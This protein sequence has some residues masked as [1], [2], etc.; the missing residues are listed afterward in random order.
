M[1]GESAR[2]AFVERIRAALGRA[3]TVS[4]PEPP[5]PPAVDEALVR[6]VKPETDLAGT[7]A[8]RAAGA[9]MK[10]HRCAAA[11]CAA[12]V[13]GILR[14][15]RAARVWVERVEAGA[16]ELAGRVRAAGIGVVGDECGEGMEALFDLDAGVTGVASAIA[17]TGSVVLASGPGRRRGAFMVPP[18]H[19][20]VVH[21]GQIVADLLDL[22]GRIGPPP[23][24]PTALTIVSGPSKTADIEGILITGVHGPG[25]VHVVLVASAES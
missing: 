7:F 1:S 16:E 24:P 2:R 18:V 17:E 14:E 12:T 15:I 5:P 10:V 11:E 8:S 23:S 3:G 21:E 19:I 4:V 20:A 22:W 25:Q 13:V 9:G 6:L